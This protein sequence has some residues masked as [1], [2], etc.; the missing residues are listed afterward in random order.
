MGQ[1]R[2]AGRPCSAIHLAAGPPAEFGPADF[3]LRCTPRPARLPA[4]RQPRLPSHGGQPA[5]RRAV[6]LT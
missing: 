3:D 6:D 5:V 4:V 1:G 2:R